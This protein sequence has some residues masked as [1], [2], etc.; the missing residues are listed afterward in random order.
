[1]GRMHKRHVPASLSLPI[2]QPSEFLSFPEV[3]TKE[4]DDH[5][6]QWEKQDFND[7]VDEFGPAGLKRILDEQY[8]SKLM[9]LTLLN[10]SRIV[11]M[12]H[13]QQWYPSLRKPVIHG[14]LRRGETMNVIS[15]SKMGKSYLVLNLIMNVISG[16]KLFDE[17]L[18]EPGRVLV[19]D[20]ELHEET[21]VHRNQCVGTAFNADMSRVS[22]QIDYMPL[23]GELVDLEGL[24]TE[25]D[26]VQRGKYA[27]II[28]D[29][30]YKLFPQNV[31][32]ND[33]ADMA[34]LYNLVDK[35]AVM[36]D[37]AFVI[38]HHSSKGSQSERTVTDVGSGAGAISRAADTH[39]VLRSHEEDGLIVVDAAAR[40]WPPIEP[41]CARFKYPLWV[42]DSN[43]D[44]KML[45]GRMSK[46]DKARQGRDEKKIKDMELLDSKLLPKI[47]KPMN[48]QEIK[49]L[50]IAMNLELSSWSDNFVR[51]TLTR[52]RMQGGVREIEKKVG[53]KAATYQYIEGA[54]LK[55]WTGDDQAKPAQHGG[56]PPL[57]DLPE[58]PPDGQEPLTNDVQPECVPF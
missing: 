56:E 36:L 24:A 14:L 42:R 20:N 21:I 7:V 5:N 8:R 51:D 4:Q 38:I 41:F 46:Q 34:N 44:P 16:T 3:I 28:L 50:A 52:W 55:P 6:A 11:G 45:K 12:K 32:E 9:N 39:L 30:F 43:A 10:S 23:R 15:G 47:D 40:S 29:A 19:C 22:L 1:M 17:F 49:A 58:A 31:D 54:Q 13:M 25:F 18:C 35:Y 2:Q 26:N 33:N 48:W 37:S 27:V 53:S 57:E